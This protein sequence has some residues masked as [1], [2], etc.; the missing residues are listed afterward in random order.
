MHESSDHTCAEV[1]PTD[2]NEMIMA[3]HTRSEM[4]FEVIAGANLGWKSPLMG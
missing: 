4:L 1:V 3:K 2:I